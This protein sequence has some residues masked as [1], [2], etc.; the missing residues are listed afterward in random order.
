MQQSANNFVDSSKFGIKRKRPTEEQGSSNE[1][2]NIPP[3][4]KFRNYKLEWT[5]IFLI[6][7]NPF[8]SQH[9]ALTTAV[10]ESKQQR[11]WIAQLR[12][13]RALD[14]ASKGIILSLEE[15]YHVTTH[16]KR[17]KAMTPYEKE[18][19]K[20]EGK[21]VKT[22]YSLTRHKREGS[23]TFFLPY[24]TVNYFCSY[25][26]A[27]LDYIEFF[28]S[29]QNDETDL[30]H[31]L[32]A[33]ARFV[34]ERRIHKADIPFEVDKVNVDRVLELQSRVLHYISRPLSDEESEKWEHMTDSI[35][36]GF[37]KMLENAEV[38]AIEKKIESL[39]EKLMLNQIYKITLN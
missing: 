14:N 17:S 7:L 20:L 3:P 34:Q 2:E 16:L 22:G 10:D 31:I 24:S 19:V 27:M 38:P 28:N 35:T 36:P 15:M 18:W 1:Q 12:N 39:I 8:Q 23:N 5:E 37:I 32:K 33:C 6:Q 11:I 13:R 29:Y 4:P 30:I 26:R 21:P 9:V 25:I